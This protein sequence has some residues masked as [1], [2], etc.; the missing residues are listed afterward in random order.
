MCKKMGLCLVTLFLAFTFG[1]GSG[2]PDAASTADA[3]YYGGDIVTVNDA[4]LRV[5]ALAVKDGTIL[6]VGSRAEIESKHMGATTQMIDLGG[7]TFC[8]VF[9]IPTVTISVRSQ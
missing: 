9:S 3:I 2:G 6:T 8:L 7:K 5:E 4:Q 1:C